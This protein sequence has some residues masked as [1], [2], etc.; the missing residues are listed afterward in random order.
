MN[1]KERLAACRAE[2]HAG[3]QEGRQEEQDS[4]GKQALGSLPPQRQ[5]LLKVKFVFK[6]PGT[7]VV[8]HTSGPQSTVGHRHLVVPER[9]YQAHCRSY[10][11]Q[12][13]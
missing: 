6:K 2:E 9:S 8:G 10:E 3:R 1:H 5:A 4:E 13:D 7:L 12:C 11:S